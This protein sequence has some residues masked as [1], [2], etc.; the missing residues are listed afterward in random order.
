MNVCIMDRQLALI[1][2]HEEQIFPFPDTTGLH[3]DHN[4]P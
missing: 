1:E 3:N 4:T 2:S